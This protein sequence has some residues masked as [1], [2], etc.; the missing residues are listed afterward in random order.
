MSAMPNPSG[1]RRPKRRHHGDGTVVHRTDRW[2]RKPWAAVVP[3]TDPS[4]RRREMW[5]SAVSRQEADELRKAELD[6]QVR[7][8]FGVDLLA[9]A[10]NVGRLVDGFVAE[11]VAY[12]KTIPTR[13]HGE[14]ETMV[15]RGVNSGRL[16]RDLAR[17]IE[18]RFGVAES[19]ARLIARDQVGKFYGKVNTLRQR[20]MGVERF[21]WRTVGDERVRDEHTDREIESD[22][23][24]GGT[25]YSYDDPP[26]GELPGE[27]INCRCFPEPVFDDILDAVEAT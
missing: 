13:L 15:T 23:E 25:P 2:R 16:H 5:L 18:E 22:P 21:V 7:A 10:P 17:D 26:E 3:Y 8:A 6:R 9:Q 4:G 14:I 27:P 24:Q 19:R 11:N 12:I 20:A 1:K